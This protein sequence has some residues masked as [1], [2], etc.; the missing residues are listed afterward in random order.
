MCWRVCFSAMRYSSAKKNCLAIYLI[1]IV[2]FYA[3][4]TQ[5]LTPLTMTVEGQPQN[6]G[7]FALPGSQQPGPFI[8]LGQ[9]IIDKNQLQLFLEPTYLKGVNQGFLE[10]Y[11]SLLYGLSDSASLYLLAPWALNYRNG[12]SHSQGLADTTLQFEYAFYQSADWYKTQSATALATVTLPTGSFN[13]NPPTGYGT[14]TAFLGGTFNESFVNWSW[15]VSSGAFIAPTRHAIHLG[16][17]YLYQGGI[18]H[19]VLSQ[20]NEFT[21]FGLLEFDGQYTEKSSNGRQSNPSSG[22]NTIL[23][24]PS[25]WF[26]N[27]KFIWQLGFSFPILQHLN[28][29]QANT[30][31]YLASTLGWTFN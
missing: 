17:Q 10:F 23:L 25:I 4:P 14:S 19:I 24:T 15:F 11:P 6:Q 26:S 5:A 7:I 13:K 2:L 27:Q 16:S 3:I 22:G 28:G 8:S 30:N 18:G 21:W 20:Q 1:S 9:N 29:T 31:Y 12:F